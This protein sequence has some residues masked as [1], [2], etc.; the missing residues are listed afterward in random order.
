MLQDKD[1]TEKER[2]AAKIRAKT[3]NVARI[4]KDTNFQYQS[5]RKKRRKEW[6]RG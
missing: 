6:S 2:R 5:D 4:K 1:I 3:T